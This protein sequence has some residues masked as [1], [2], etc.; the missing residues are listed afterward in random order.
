MYPS[1]QTVIPGDDYTLSIVFENGE[2][3][4]L[5]MKPVLGL[6][7]FQRLRDYEV[8]RKVRVAFDTIE[9]EGGIDLDPEY[10]YARCKAEQAA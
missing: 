9:W 1:V 2:T 10:V 6:G 7:V 4:I 5:D 3:G 8:F